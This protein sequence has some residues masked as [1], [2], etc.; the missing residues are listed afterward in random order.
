MGRHYVAIAV[1]AFV[2]S[3][4][5][6][7]PAWKRGTA[8]SRQRKSARFWIQIAWSKILLSLAGR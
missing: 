6:G 2:M 1:G 3:R 8:Q 5:L 4:Q 7:V